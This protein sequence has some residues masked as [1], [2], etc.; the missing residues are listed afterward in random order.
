[1]NK[2]VEAEFGIDDDDIIDDLENLTE[3]D[4]MEDEEED[5]N[6]SND[7]DSFDFE[8]YYNKRTDKE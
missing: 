6:E 3:E 5:T 2:F 7:K 1:M 8:M 4:F